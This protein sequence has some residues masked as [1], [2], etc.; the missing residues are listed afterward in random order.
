MVM[1]PVSAM[2]SWALTTRFI[3]TCSIW[4]L[5]ARMQAGAAAG[6]SLIS[7]LSRMVRR[8]MPAKEATTS[9]R[10]TIRMSSVCL[11]PKVRSCLVR[12]RAFRAAWVMRLDLL[13][14][15]AGRGQVAPEHL[16]IPEDR[17]QQIVE[18]VGDAAGQ[19][20]DRLHLLGLEQLGFD[21]PVIGDVRCR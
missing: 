16:R 7:M 18:V 14:I 1:T 20:A 12:S 19:L 8:K 17:R 2:A 5:S 11:R 21:I 3:T 6:S 13:D 9:F 4:V 10:S 15:D